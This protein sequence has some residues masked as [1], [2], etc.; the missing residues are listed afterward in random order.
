MLFRSLAKLH[1]IA[2]ALIE[3][4]TLEGHEIKEL[5]EYG[6]ILTKDETTPK[7]PPEEGTPAPIDPEKVGAEAGQKVLEPVPEPAPQS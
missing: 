3:R 7:N 2:E 1:L 5:M 6:H 4:E